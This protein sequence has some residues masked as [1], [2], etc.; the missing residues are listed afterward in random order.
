MAPNLT[1]SSFRIYI[2]DPSKLLTGINWETCSPIGKSNTPIKTSNGRKIYMMS[3]K[4]VPNTLT[5]S[6]AANPD[7]DFLINQ[8]LDNFCTTDTVIEGMTNGGA[9]L[10]LVPLKPCANDE[11]YSRKIK[12]FNLMPSSWN[13]WDADLMDE[14]A[15]SR[16]EVVFNYT[17]YTYS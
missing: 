12:V 9:I 13:L 3:G 15:M 5:V 10:M 14:T 16:T 2:E 4:S 6:K 11:T 7:E 8:W 1:K 17:N